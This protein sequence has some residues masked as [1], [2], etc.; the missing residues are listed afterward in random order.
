MQTATVKFYYR[1]AEAWGQIAPK[2][3]HFNG[4]TWDALI[5]TRG[6]SGEAMWVQATGVNSYSPFA[7]KDPNIPTYRM[8]LPLIIR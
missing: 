8:Y 7:L 1:S 5:S 6:G 4:S 2:A 3:Y